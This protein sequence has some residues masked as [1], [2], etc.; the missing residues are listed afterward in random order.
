RTIRDPNLFSASPLVSPAIGDRF[1]RILTAALVLVLASTARAGDLIPTNPQFG[2]LR[3]A[4]HKVDVLIDNQIALTKLEQVF[5]NDNNATLEGQYTFP[6]PKG[7]SLIDFSMTV[8]G[9]LIRGELLE[10]N[11][12]RQ[13]YEGIVQRSKDPGLLEQIGTNLFRVRVFPILAHAQQKIE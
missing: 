10:K 3:V 7:A 6:L 4:S 1:M 13:I 12:A 11:K 9:K 8:N 5:A 2:P